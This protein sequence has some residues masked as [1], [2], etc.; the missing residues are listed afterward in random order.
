VL[1]YLPFVQHATL[2]ASVVVTAVTGVL[3]EYPLFLDA[4]RAYE[5]P[6]CCVRDCGNRA[7]RG[8]YAILSFETREKAAPKAAGPSQQK[9]SHLRDAGSAEEKL[10]EGLDS[11]SPRPDPASGSRP[12]CGPSLKNFRDVG[13]CAKKRRTL[14]PRCTISRSDIETALAALPGPHKP[15]PAPAPGTGSPKPPRPSRRALANY[16]LSEISRYRARSESNHNRDGTFL[17]A[18]EGFDSSVIAAVEPTPVQR[19]VLYT[20]ADVPL[21]AGRLVVSQ[22]ASTARQE[23]QRGPNERGF[24]DGEH[25]RDPPYISS[26]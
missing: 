14:K 16:F 4:L 21:N 22:V 1:P 10:G 9:G 2:L 12:A 5:N 19:C 26:Q 18:C 17:S 11:D 7:G 25:P 3:S 6:F 8:A 20:F 24:D 23:H 15:F 13:D